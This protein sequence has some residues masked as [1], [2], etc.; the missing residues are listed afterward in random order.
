MS[1]LTW[2]TNITIRI[3]T[4]KETIRIAPVRNCNRSVLPVVTHIRKMPFG[5]DKEVP[6]R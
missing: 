1:L 4:V 2:T 5:D 6:F 3:R